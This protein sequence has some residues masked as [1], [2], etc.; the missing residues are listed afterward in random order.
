MG[1]REER[2]RIMTTTARSV[3]GPDHD[4]P[5]RARRG[6]GQDL[7]ADRERIVLIESCHSTWIF[8]I[9]C[10]RFRRVLKGIEIQDHL[11]MTEW[12]SYEV[13]ELDPRSDA[14]VVV[15]NPQKNRMLRSWRHTGGVCAQCGEDSREWSPEDI[16]ALL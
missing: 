9:A 7:H 8:D 5:Q 14:F 12:R 15:L 4:R 16:G 2:G 6:A 11:V 3:N 10:R 1:R 13:L